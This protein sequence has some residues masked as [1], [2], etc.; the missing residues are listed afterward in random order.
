MFQAV[1]A[2]AVA[3]ASFAPRPQSRAGVLLAVRL[4]PAIRDP[5]S[6]GPSAAAG[7]F[8]LVLL[9]IPFQS[10]ELTKTREWI[11]VSRHLLKVFAGKFP[12]REYELRKSRCRLRSNRTQLS[13]WKGDHHR[14]STALPPRRAQI[15]NNR[16]LRSRPS[17]VRG[18]IQRSHKLR[19]EGIR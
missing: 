1:A 3:D 7:R 10:F 13:Y 14:E 9:N 4:N 19:H 5:R 17:S 12:I 6:R 18:G 8:A 15:T 2:A 16:S 11:V